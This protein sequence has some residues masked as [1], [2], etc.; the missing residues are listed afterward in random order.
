[1]SFDVIWCH[2]MS[3]VVMWCHD[4]MWCHVLSCD[5]MCCHV[6]S[7]DVM[8]CHVLS[9]DVMVLCMASTIRPVTDY[10]SL[11]FQAMEN[12]TRLSCTKLKPCAW[13]HHK[14]FSYSKFQI[15]AMSLD[16]PHNAQLLKPWV[17]NH[18]WNDYVASLVNVWNYG[19]CTTSLCSGV[20][21]YTVHRMFSRGDLIMLKN[22]PTMPC[23]NVQRKYLHVLCAKMQSEAWCCDHNMDCWY[24]PSF[25]A[26]ARTME[27]LEL[28]N[29]GLSVSWGKP[30]QRHLDR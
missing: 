15:E 30:C 26:W 23:C 8:W 19:C 1:M 11:V 22:P 21:I 29:G 28:R 20:C 10:N 27:E 14:R 4:V 2:V 3:C 6:M 17:W 18:C 25:S 16:P 5:V 13:I 12:T 24:A 7:Y 9:C